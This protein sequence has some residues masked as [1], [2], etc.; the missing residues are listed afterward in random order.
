MY[1]EGLCKDRTQFVKCL[2]QNRCLETL[3]TQDPMTKSFSELI[4]CSI[5]HLPYPALYSKSSSYVNKLSLLT[6]N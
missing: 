2:A 1:L 6:F 5:Q 4:A 3:I